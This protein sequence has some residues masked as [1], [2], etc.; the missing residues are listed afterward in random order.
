MKY[1]IYYILVSFTI[2]TFSSCKKDK[3]EKESI[4][5]YWKSIG[6]GKILAIENS[7]YSFYDITNISC[8]PSKQGKIID[9]RNAIQ[10]Q[11]DTLS[12]HIGLSVYYYTRL[13]KFPNLCNKKLIESKLKDPIYNFEVMSSTINEHFAHFDRNKI[14]WQK[15][16][17][18]QK[19]K[20]TK[21]TTDLQLYLVLDEMIEKLKDNHGDLEPT[22]EIYEQAETLNTKVEENSQMKE[23]GDFKIAQLVA[24]HFLDDNMTKDSKLIHWGKLENNIGYIQVKVMWLFGDLGLSDTLIKQKGFVGA[25]VEAFNKLDENSYIEAEVKGINFIMDKVM[26]DLNDS[27]F[28]ILDVRFNGGGQDVVGLEILKRFTNKRIQVAKKRAK[29]INSYT[30]TT[31]IFLDFSIL[32]YEKPVYLL[33]SQQSASAT[34]FMALASMELDNVKRIG[35]HTNGALSDALEKKLPNG[36]GFSISNEE[37]FDN[38][39]VCYEY[40]GIPVNY[41]LNYPKDRQTFFRSVANDLEKDKQSI[42]NAINELQNEKSITK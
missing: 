21:E 41:E 15:L 22:D 11:N 1:A 25:Y 32:P 8:L 16:Y 27:D 39:N 31:P 17:S 13:N 33:T 20:I 38:N 24:E 18:T 35:S 29:Y 10:L 34:D 28:L 6:Y 19:N 42:L 30:K 5:G 9:F 2:C 36:W 14:N 4:K 37:Y 3:S 40:I 7:N 12:I 26:K 23:Y